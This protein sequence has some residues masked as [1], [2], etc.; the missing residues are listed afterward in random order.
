MTEKNTGTVKF[1]LD[2]KKLPTLPRKRLDALRKLNDDEIDHIDI[3]SQTNV[4][5]T[6]PG[7]LV[8][9][10]NKGK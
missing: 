5:W 9:S 4:K 7:A 10:G 6:R 8:F 3:P 1:R 2:S